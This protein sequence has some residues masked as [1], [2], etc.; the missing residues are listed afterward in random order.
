MRDAIKTLGG[1]PERV[2]PLALSSWSST[3]RPGD[4]FG[5]GRFAANTPWNSRETRT[6]CISQVGPDG[7]SQLLCRAAGMASAHQVNLESPG[8]VVFTA[9]LDGGAV[10]YP[11][12]LVGTDSHT[13][14]INGLVCW[15]WG[16]RIEAGAAM[17]GQPVSS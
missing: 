16:W 6:L 9:E 5:S 17:L 11:D 14:M 1:D 10:A 12:T 8:R 13:T 2:N 7:L 15:G 4:E 3:I